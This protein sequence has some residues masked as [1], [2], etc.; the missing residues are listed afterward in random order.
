MIDFARHD[1]S[2]ESP[3]FVFNEEVVRFI[4]RIVVTG[5]PRASALRFLVTASL[6]CPHVIGK[7]QVLAQFA[8]EIGVTRQNVSSLY[9]DLCKELGVASPYNW[10]KKKK[11][12]FRLSVENKAPD[13][14]ELQT[15]F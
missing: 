6:V 8:K 4:S 1:R 10:K 9:S 7:Q 2:P 5:K 13:K 3:D 15:V 12:R 14:N 11:A